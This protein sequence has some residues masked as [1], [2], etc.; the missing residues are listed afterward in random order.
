MTH[1]T[2]GELVVLK[3]ERIR[4]AESAKEQEELRL[5]LY[6]SV[7]EL[8]ANHTDLAPGQITAI[9]QA[10]LLAEGLTPHTP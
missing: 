7:L 5:D 3:L 1:L 2:P 8:F 9:A 10:A 6:K 4:M